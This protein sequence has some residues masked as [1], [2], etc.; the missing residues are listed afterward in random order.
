MHYR[1]SKI[2]AVVLVLIVLLVITGCKDDNTQD[3]PETTTLSTTSVDA[4][5][6][7]NTNTGTTDYNKMFNVEKKDLKKM[8]LTEE[9]A[10]DMYTDSNGIEYGFSPS[11]NCLVS[12]TDTN[13]IGNNS[14][15]NLKKLLDDEALWI[16]AESILS[17]LTD[18]D[19][20]SE[21]KLIRNSDDPYSSVSFSFYYY[22][23]GYKTTDYAYVMLQY[24]G[25]F[26]SMSLS[27]Y[28]ETEDVDT[29]IINDD[30]IIC[31]LEEAIKNDY[32][33]QMK[34]EVRDQILGK[35]DEKLYMHFTLSVEI[36]SENSIKEG[37]YYFIPIE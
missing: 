5:I 15:L 8:E 20:Y 34:Y 16:I 35:R 14:K 36:N 10:F 23:D 28:R 22:I 1:I 13:V 30:D 6:N 3:N 29:S 33:K 19:R 27:G 9:F 17:Y 12:V 24:D 4:N 31:K 26:Y 32:G 25:T 11:L 7:T 21:K 2:F 37:K 18:V